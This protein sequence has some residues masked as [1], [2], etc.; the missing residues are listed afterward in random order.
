MRQENG[1]RHPEKGFGPRV[2]GCALKKASEEPEWE[3]KPEG[4]SRSSSHE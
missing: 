4:L 3:E 1:H 2:K